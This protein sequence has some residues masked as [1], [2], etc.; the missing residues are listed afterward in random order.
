VPLSHSIFKADR[1]GRLGNTEMELEASAEERCR[2]G[3][4]W[5]KSGDTE[6]SGRHSSLGRLLV[7]PSQGL[8][9]CCKWWGTKQEGVLM[10]AAGT[11]RQRTA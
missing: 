8:S 6:E 2:P 7:K 4:N 11:S 5:E 10:G 1:L 9:S 3:L